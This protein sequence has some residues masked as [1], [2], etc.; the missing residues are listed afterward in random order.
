MKKKNKYSIGKIKEGIIVFDGKLEEIREHITE[1]DPTKENPG[2][3]VEDN[4]VVCGKDLY[5]NDEFTKRIAMMDNDDE[6]VGWMCPFCFSEFT[7]NDDI[8]HLMTRKPQGEA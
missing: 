6:V 8:I 5:H 4:C 7:P 3:H 2:K 1:E